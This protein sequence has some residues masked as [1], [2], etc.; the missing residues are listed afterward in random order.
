MKHPHR[1]W[2]KMNDS[3]DIKRAQEEKEG[4]GETMGLL[5][6]TRSTEKREM[7]LLESTRGRMGELVE[8]WL[9]KLQSMLR[10]AQCV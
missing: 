7:G 4:R 9:V 1:H 8:C 5:E 2:I 10:A 6:S 3:L